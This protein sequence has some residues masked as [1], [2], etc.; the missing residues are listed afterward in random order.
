MAT[1]VVGKV[2]VHTLL[3]FLP[4]IL[5]QERSVLVAMVISHPAKNRCFLCLM[6]TI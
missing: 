6:K 1:T 3:K 5:N 2:M 4:D